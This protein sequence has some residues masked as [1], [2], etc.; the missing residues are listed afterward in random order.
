MTTY[1]CDNCGHEFTLVS[2]DGYLPDCPLCWG[3]CLNVY[4]VN[5]TADSPESHEEVKP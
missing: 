2:D 3:G 1:V 5:S 4:R